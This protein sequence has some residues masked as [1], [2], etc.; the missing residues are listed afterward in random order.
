MAEGATYSVVPFINR[1]ALGAVA[2]IVGAGGNVG[3]VLYAQ[4]LLRSGSS[5]Q[6]AFF[7]FGFIVAAVGFLGLLVRFSP[8]EEQAAFDE[9]KKL[10]ALQKEIDAKAAIA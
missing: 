4:Y 10:E 1:K 7:A 6:E 9:Q 8:E 3:A 5:L 2:G